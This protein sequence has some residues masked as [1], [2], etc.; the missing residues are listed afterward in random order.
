MNINNS[1]NNNTNINNSS[2]ENKIEIKNDNKFEFILN[3]IKDYTEI[4]KEQN[5]LI[6]N[7]YNKLINNN[8]KKIL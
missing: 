8:I 1:S 2:L 5:D 6:I 7:E 4:T 3:K